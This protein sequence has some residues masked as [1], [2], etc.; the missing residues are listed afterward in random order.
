MNKKRIIKGHYEIGI[1]VNSVKFNCGHKVDKLNHS[2]RKLAC[3]LRNPALG[4]SVLGVLGC[5]KLQYKLIVHFRCMDNE[6]NTKGK[7]EQASAP[8]YLHTCR[9][10]T[11]E[12]RTNPT[13]W[14][15]SFRE[16]QPAHGCR[17]R[18]CLWW[19]LP[20]P[21]FSWGKQNVN[22]VQLVSTDGCACRC[23]R[24]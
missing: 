17:S 15:D 2:Q 6:N 4:K 21:S 5:L 9:I 14:I 13:L 20:N 12:F 16:V 23:C 18:F 11:H 3:Q 7:W 1:Y 24:R 19:V 8:K 10:S 22:L